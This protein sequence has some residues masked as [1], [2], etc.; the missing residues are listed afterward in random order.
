MSEKK[1][2]GNELKTG[3]SFSSKTETEQLYD[4]MTG[5]T[6][7]EEKEEQETEETT[8]QED[9]EI[10]SEEELEIQREIESYQSKIEQL[11]AKLAA[12]EAQYIDAMK[13]EQMKKAYYSDEQIVRYIGHIQGNNK[14]EIAESVSQLDIPPANDNFV[15]PS[16]FNGRSAKP[17]TV[18]H[19]EI[20]RQAF[21]RIKHKIFPWMRGQ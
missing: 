19:A 11:D 20:G 10:L 1:D 5:K 4:D 9:E 16:P 8:E 7:A 14:E 2:A 12:H 15:D 18:D 6:E 13:R 17:K 3:S 21:G